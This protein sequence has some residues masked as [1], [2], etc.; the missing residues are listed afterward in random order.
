MM[1]RY[2]ETFDKDIKDAIRELDAGMEKQ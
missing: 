2:A 1:E